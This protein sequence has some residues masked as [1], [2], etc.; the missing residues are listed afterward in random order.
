MYYE[1]HG[2]GQP[3]VLIHGAM[4]TIESCFA[5]LLPALATARQVI[6]VELQGHGHSADIDRPLSYEQM[7]EDTGGLLRQLGYRRS[8]FRRL[9]PGRRRRT[10]ARHR[11]SGAGAA[12]RICRWHR[13]PVTG[14][15]SG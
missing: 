6:A 4:G 1:I 10:A 2:H 12:A 11:A 3:L 9:Q 15:D 7:A 5:G 8:R 14:A 13:E